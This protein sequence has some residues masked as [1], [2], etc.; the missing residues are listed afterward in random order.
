MKKRDEK[1]EK[2]RLMQKEADRAKAK[3]Q[4]R[5]G[6]TRMTEHWFVLYLRIPCL[7]AFFCFSSPSEALKGPQ[8]RT[9][10]PQ[11]IGI[12]SWIANVNLMVKTWVWPLK[13]A[14]V[15]FQQFKS[16]WTSLMPA[17]TWALSFSTVLRSIATSLWSVWE[18]TLSSMTVSTDQSL[19]WLQKWAQLTTST[20][21]STTSPEWSIALPQ[22]PKVL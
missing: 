11:P 3:A 1:L 2:K 16:A 7:P 12:G 8:P 5:V 13:T 14:S 15:F 20:V 6:G 9:R 22:N 4:M 17:M 21:S 19:N 18:S 10:R